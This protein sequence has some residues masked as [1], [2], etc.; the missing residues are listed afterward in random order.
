MDKTIRMC[1]HCSEPIVGRADKKFCSDQ[2]RARA[3]NQRKGSDQG[4]Q[5]MREVN[6]TLRQNRQV[7]QKAGPVGKTTLRRQVL[8]LAG[9]DFLYF[10]H[11]YRT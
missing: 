2:C 11:L 5:L 4:E 10:T 1:G 8:E 6:A 9:F 3:G 7:L